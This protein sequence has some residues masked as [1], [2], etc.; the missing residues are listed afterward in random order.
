MLGGHAAL[1][2]PE[3]TSNMQL[4][5]YFRRFRR[6][7][8]CLHGYLA[9]TLLTLYLTTGVLLIAGIGTSQLHGWLTIGIGLAHGL[10]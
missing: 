9:L 7:L 6:R 5:T 1:S 3:G 8:R 2:A 4:E 10:S